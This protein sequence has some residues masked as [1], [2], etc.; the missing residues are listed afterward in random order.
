MDH[1]RKRQCQIA[2]IKLAELQVVRESPTIPFN[3]NNTRLVRIWAQA[4]GGKITGFDQKRGMVWQ[5]PQHGSEH[6]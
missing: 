3:Q 2:G 5:M 1:G 4:L 6:E